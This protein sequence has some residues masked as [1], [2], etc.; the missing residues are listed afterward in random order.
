MGK[1]ERVG[2]LSG[3]LTAKPRREWF[4]HEIFEDQEWIFGDTRVEGLDDVGGVDGGRCLGLAHEASNASISA[5]CAPED[6]DGDLAGQDL[7]LG[8]VHGSV[9]PNADEF[10]EPIAVELRPDEGFGFKHS[11]IMA[12][13][14]S[15]AQRTSWRAFTTSG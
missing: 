2:E 8:A 4:A 6:L 1:R 13:H 7:V 11:P 15:F 9:T 14:R 12:F 3:T 5:I 10:E